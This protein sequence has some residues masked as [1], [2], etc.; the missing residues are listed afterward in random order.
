M[1]KT[2]QEAHCPDVAKQEIKKKQLYLKE[3]IM[4]M[5]YDP[6]DFATFLENEKEGGIDIENWTYEELE[7]LVHLF[8]KS[9]DIFN[10]QENSEAPEYS[11]PDDL[12]LGGPTPKKDGP[13]E[14][15]SDPKSSVLSK[16]PF[17]DRVRP[18]AH[19]GRR[20]GTCPSS[21]FLM[22]RTTT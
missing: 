13:S 3:N 8:R 14:T 20:A 17:V 2:N 10:E 11:D 19:L 22:H 9:R 4:T 1:S 6:D 12:L 7:T 15:I 5:G 21:L 18:V 16:P